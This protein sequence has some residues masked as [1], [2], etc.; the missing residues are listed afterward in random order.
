MLFKSDVG[1]DDSAQVVRALETYMGLSWLFEPSRIHGVSLMD[2][3]KLSCIIRMNVVDN[4]VS[5]KK[6]GF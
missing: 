4:R 2:D 5:N 3:L 6:Q 1:I